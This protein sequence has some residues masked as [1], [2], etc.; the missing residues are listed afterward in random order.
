MIWRAPVN[1]SRELLMVLMDHEVLTIR[2]KVLYAACNVYAKIEQLMDE[3]KLVRTG[4]K[5]KKPAALF[6]R[7]L[8][9]SRMGSLR[10]DVLELLVETGNESLAQPFLS[11]SMGEWWALGVLRFYDVE[12]PPAHENALA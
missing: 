6:E 8:S 9:L 1:L 2:A 10:P 12:R 4:R 5:L 11:L 7:T 3:T